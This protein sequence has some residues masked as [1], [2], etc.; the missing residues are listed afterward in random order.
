MFWGPELSSV[1]VSWPTTSKKNLTV[2]LEVVDFAKNKLSV[3]AKKIV[4]SKNL[5]I[6]KKL[7]PDG[8][9]L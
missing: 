8:W 3:F 9:I 6:E 2:M 7:Y 1:V 5:C 4:F